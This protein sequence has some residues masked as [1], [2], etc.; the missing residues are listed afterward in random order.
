MSEEN[1]F[2][3]RVSYVKHG[4]LRY[5]GH[6]ELIHTVERIVRRA[7]LP[8]AVTQG[9]SPH[10][11]IAFSSALPV[12][13]ASDCEWY[14]V[15]LTRYVPAAEAFDALAAASPADLAPA[16]AG[17]VERREPALEAALTRARYR[18]ALTLAAPSARDA[19]R[20]EEVLAAVVARREVRYLRGRKVKRID[21]VCT[22]V[23][24]K[25]APGGGVWELALDTRSSAEGALRPEVLLRAWEKALALETAGA[26]GTPAAELVEE[27]LADPLDVRPYGVF[28]HCEITRV[29]QKI[30]DKRGILVEPLPL[31]AHPA[32]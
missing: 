24:A 6:L 2:R 17:Y 29:F 22:F 21:L 4:R 15:F 16:R 31:A 23:G 20:A 26:P 27:A 18:V 11:K 1:L 19:A 30:E 10:M 3:L 7:Q 14:D 25:L 12:G 9:F 13:T 32:R 28:A 8:Y 5:L